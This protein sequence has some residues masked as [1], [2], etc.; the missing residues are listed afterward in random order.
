LVSHQHNQS[1]LFF[2]YFSFSF[3]I[4]FIFLQLDLLFTT[5]TSK[6]VMVHA[7][8][9]YGRHLVRRG[10]PHRSPAAPLTV[11]D[12]DKTGQS[13]FYSFEQGLPVPVRFVCQHILATPLGNQS[14]PTMAHYGIGIYNNNAIISSFYANPEVQYINYLPT[15]Q[16]YNTNVVDRSHVAIHVSSSH[17]NMHNSYS[18]TNMSRWSNHNAY[19]FEHVS[20]IHNGF[21]PPYS[22]T[23]PA[24]HCTPQTHM[25]MSNCY[26]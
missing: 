7:S 3:S 25:P 21:V 26:S 13:N 20:N 22:S 12:P 6:V 4:L 11:V 14:S 16:A 23:K 19:I 15:P 1:N 24:S 18:S 5:T 2:S 8:P 17:V 10:A 9:P